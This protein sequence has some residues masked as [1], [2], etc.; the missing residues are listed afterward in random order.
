MQQLK[1]LLRIVLPSVTSHE[2]AL[3]AIHTGF[4][5]SRTFLSIY[6]AQLDGSMVKSLVDKNGKAFL[7]D[8]TRWLLVGRQFEVFCFPPSFHFNSFFF[9]PF[10][11]KALP[12]TFVNS[13]IK[14]FESKLALAF[15][16]RLSEY[17]Y[18]LYM[19]NEVY[20]KVVNLDR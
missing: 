8:L 12:A 18:N 3:L 19:N 5:F 4:L 6:V 11:K 14:Y 15:R 9:F 20:Y 1:F 10:H 13:M 2:A 17:A 16:A 7:W